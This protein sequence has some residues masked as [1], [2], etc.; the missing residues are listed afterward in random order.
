M[1]SLWLFLAS[2]DMLRM[3]LPC[4]SLFWSIQYSHTSSSST[5]SC[6]ITD[7][8]EFSV[9][10]ITLTGTSTENK[11]KNKRIEQHEII[12]HGYSHFIWTEEESYLVWM[13]MSA[14]LGLSI[15]LQMSSC[16]TGIAVLLDT[17]RSER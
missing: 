10:R 15:N 14:L 12:G 17:H 4:G 3:D 6:I 16:V 8:R 13:R 7:S 11:K 1:S 5:S 9:C 2:R